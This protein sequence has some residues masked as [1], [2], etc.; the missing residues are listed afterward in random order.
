[1]KPVSAEQEKRIAIETTKLIQEISAGF[2]R[3]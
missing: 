1:M 3:N 2:E